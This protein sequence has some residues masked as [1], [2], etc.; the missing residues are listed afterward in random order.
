MERKEIIYNSFIEFF[1]W[2]DASEVEDLDTLLNEDVALHLEIEKKRPT[3]T[4]VAEAI[5]KVI[6]HKIKLGIAEDKCPTDAYLSIQSSLITDRWIHTT[7]LLRF[8]IKW[9]KKGYFDPIC[10][11]FYI[12]DIR[13]AKNEKD[14]ERLLQIKVCLAER[15]MRQCII[16]KEIRIDLQK[17]FGQFDG[18]QVCE[19]CGNLMWSG[20]SW[21]GTTYCDEDCVMEGERIDRKD[22]NEYLEDACDPDGC[23]YYTEW[24]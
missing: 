8:I 19:N 24:Y 4:N 16:S 1:Q 7:T 11:E 13:Y 14:S 21:D 22:M 5:K 6:F 15:I 18:A 12:R 2:M 9:K 20:Y 3:K 10:T 23:C 17:T